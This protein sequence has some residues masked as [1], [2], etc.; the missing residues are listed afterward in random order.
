MSIG[1]AIGMPKC[2]DLLIC[3]SCHL[4][5][6]DNGCVCVIIL[7]MNSKMMGRDALYQAL[8]A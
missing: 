8:H 4:V 7:H 6:A 3:L 2:I 5:C 1:T